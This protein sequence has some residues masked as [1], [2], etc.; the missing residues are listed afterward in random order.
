MYMNEYALCSNKC[1]STKAILVFNSSSN[2]IRSNL[3]SHR[4][5]LFLENLQTAHI[6]FPT[7]NAI[8]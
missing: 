2:K 6:K 3:A 7:I 1:T 8:H 5:S 4:D